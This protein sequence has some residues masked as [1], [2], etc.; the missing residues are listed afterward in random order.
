MLL[1]LW[2]LT[3]AEAIGK[4]MAELQYPETVERQ[5][6]DDIRR[7]LETGEIV[8]D[9][10]PY[11]NPAGVDGYFEYILSPVFAADGTVESAAGSPRNISDR[12][13]VEAALRE[14]ETRH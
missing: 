14:S 8:K 10:T 13:Q 4:T 1:D 12:I 9:E 3:A 6:L 2:G 5:I 7:V 11:T